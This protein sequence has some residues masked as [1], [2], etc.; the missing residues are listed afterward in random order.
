MAGCPKS[1]RAVLGQRQVETQDMCQPSFIA[2]RTVVKSHFQINFIPDLLKVSHV[3]SL[4]GLLHEASRF[5][6]LLFLVISD[7]VLSTCEGNYFLNIFQQ[8]GETDSALKRWAEHL[9][10]GQQQQQPQHLSLQWFAVARVSAQG[11]YSS[12]SILTTAS[13]LVLLL[14]H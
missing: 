4:R 5:I 2:I 3:L 11:F 13:A 8:E 12:S 14:L 7:Q 6:Y 9:H 10:W 1:I